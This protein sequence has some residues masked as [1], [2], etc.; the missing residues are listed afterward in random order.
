[1]KKK[2]ELDRRTFLRCS[3]GGAATMMGLPLLNEMLGSVA[4]AAA[5]GYVDANFVAL[6][7]PLGCARDRFFPTQFN[8][9]NLGVHTGANWN[10]NTT[11]SSLQAYKDYL[12]VYA[13]I[14]YAARG[15]DHDEEA[16]RFLTCLSPLNGFNPNSVALHT[17]G[18]SGQ[19]GKSIDQYIADHLA[20]ENNPLRSVKH[21]LQL[22]SDFRGANKQQSNISFDN[23][24]TGNLPDFDVQ[25]VYDT[26]FYG[27]NPGATANALTERQL[28]K[29]NVLDDIWNARTKSLINSLSSESKV[30]VEQY[31]N[32]IEE[33]KKKMDQLANQNP[34]GPACTKPARPG[35]ISGSGTAN[36]SNSQYK[37]HVEIMMD[38]MVLALQCN[39]HRVISYMFGPAYGGSRTWK[40]I[41]TVPSDTPNRALVQSILNLSWHD[42]SHYDQITLAGY[43]DA[44]RKEAGYTAANLVDQFHIQRLAYFAGKL[45]AAG[46]LEKTFVLFGGSLGDSDSHW[47]YSVPCL[48]LGKG[49]GA[50]TNRLYVFQ[51]YA[52]YDSYKASMAKLHVNI[53]NAFGVSSVNM[54]NYGIR[55][56]ENKDGAP[57]KV[58][59]DVFG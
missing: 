25:K 18:V 45:K 15:H 48:S 50:R 13:G 24:T 23:S 59:I 6:F 36:I 14:G 57:R 5:N 17:A 51:K 9:G 22:T 12:N 54:N 10:L 4:H 47:P 40:D 16:G 52:K 8:N 26:L 32:S 53:M 29:K 39:Q 7:K 42:Q 3:L 11:L 30:S 34:T 31:L 2:W 58:T 1:M 28:R 35:V 20:N 46:L 55:K 56:D 43:T 41:I 38:L 37:Q 33:V 19:N 44:Q 27:Y 49:A 21:S